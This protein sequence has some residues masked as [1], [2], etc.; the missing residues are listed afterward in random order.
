MSKSIIQCQDV[1]HSYSGKLVLKQVSFEI[2]AGEPIGLV[3]P[4]GAGKTTLL[5]ILCGFF[6]PSAG[7]VSIFG[8][9]P[10]N[11][12]LCGRISALPQD[13][14]FDPVFTV[15]DQ[16]IFL[17]RLQGFDVE[18]AWQEAE[19]VMDA[20]SL[21]QSLHAKPDT[22]SH[23]MAKRV[24]IAQALIGNPEL[25]LLDEPTAG[26]DPVNTRN[27]RSIIMEQARNSTF[28]ISSHDLAELGR[29]CQKVL[30]LENGVMSSMQHN[31]SETEGNSRFFT[32][33]ME[34]CP[35]DELI[36]ALKKLNGV[37][38]VSHPQKNEFLVEYLP[39]SAPAMDIDILT[40][41]AKHHWP[42]RQ[43]IRGKSLEEKLFFTD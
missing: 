31:V 12:N 38:K 22:L 13:A 3:G 2:F 8:H 11:S 1:S 26:L 35:A 4:N 41:L 15:G 42:Y 7:T 9:E 16:L 18:H 40:C 6:K 25:I 34:A 32:L 37:I 28:I 27:I 39:E 30:L 36:K 29:V 17:A 14:K 19:R 21:K 43:F 20:V 33:Q 23:G 10:G 5:S 24:A